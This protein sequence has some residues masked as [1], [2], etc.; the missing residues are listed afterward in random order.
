VLCA[1][2]AWMWA[3]DRGA[4]VVLPEDHDGIGDESLDQGYIVVPRHA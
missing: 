4:M 3:H 1:Y 2:L